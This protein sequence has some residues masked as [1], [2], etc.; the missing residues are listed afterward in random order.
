VTFSNAIKRGHVEI[1]E[2]QKG[3][4]EVVKQGAAKVSQAG[5]FFK[6]KN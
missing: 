2:A 3:N 5:S 6:C 4:G 1:L